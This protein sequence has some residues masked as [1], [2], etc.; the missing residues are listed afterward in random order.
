MGKRSIGILLVA[1]I[2]SAYFLRIYTRPTEDVAEEHSKKDTELVAQ[3]QYDEA[4]V[5]Y[6]Q[7][8]E[9]DPQ[10]VEAYNNRAITY[11]HLGLHRE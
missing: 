11:R 5:E 2:L 6:N 4:L 3:G 10:F 8:I 9:L 1:V 7:A